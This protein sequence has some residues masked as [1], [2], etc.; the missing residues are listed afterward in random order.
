MIRRCARVP[1]EFSDQGGVVHETAPAFREKP[2]GHVADKKSRM[3]N[4][5]NNVGTAPGAL[6]IG[7]PAA[8][9]AAGSRESE[10]V[11]AGYVR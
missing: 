11:D 2:A 8:Y 4:S 5:L 10:W 6:V 1:V 7:W 9:N 3:V